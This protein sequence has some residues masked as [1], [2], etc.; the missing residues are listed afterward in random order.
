MGK[1][2]ELKAMF[3]DLHRK[4]IF[5]EMELKK[6]HQELAALHRDIAAAETTELSE[7][8]EEVQE[9]GV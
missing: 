3:Y 6:V 1:V 5:L 8:A 4:Q 2:A 9:D 7:K